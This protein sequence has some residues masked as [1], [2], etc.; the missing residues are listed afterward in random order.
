M[1]E[2]H[3]R[4]VFFQDERDEWRWQL[5]HRNGNIVADSAEGYLRRGDCEQGAQAALE[6]LAENRATFAAEAAR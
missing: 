1:S 2:K 4:I 5:I 3:G 6:I